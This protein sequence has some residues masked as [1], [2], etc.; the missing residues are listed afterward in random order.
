MG[1]AQDRMKRAD[2]LYYE[3]IGE[4]FN[5]FMSE[6]D[7]TRR[8]GLI[9]NKLWPV[10]SS[11]LD[12]LEVGCGTGKIS[13]E[14]IG[15]V[16]RLTVSDISEK[17]AKDVALR[18]KCEGLREDV[19][20]MDLPDESYDLVVSSECIEHTPD[21]MGA[22]MEM[23]R[24]LKRGGYLIVTTPNKLWFPV[25]FLSMLLKIRKFEGN[26]TWVFPFAVRKWLKDNGLKLIRMGGCH[27]FP[28]Q[29]PLAKKILPFF[30]A[31]DAVLYPLMI[32][33]GFIAKKIRS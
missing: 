22:L 25:L 27:I 18:L 15:R 6:Y 16:K 7:V 4:D 5:R 23:K 14:I 21:P 24:V 20:K 3:R 26:E 10:E 12:C 32:N 28:W 30:D 31:K 13:E 19:C 8:I 2:E 1:R 11:A 33:F 9:I 29:I 17:L